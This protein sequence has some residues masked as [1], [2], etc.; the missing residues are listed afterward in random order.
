MKIA[1]GS[2]HAGFHL[3]EEIKK[4]LMEKNIQILDVGTDSETKSC[5]YPDFAEKVAKNITEG[6]ADKG[7]LICATGIGMCITANKFS[8]IRAAQCSEPVTARLSREHNDSN[9]LTLGAKIIGPLLAKD[10]VLVWLNT[11]FTGERHK[12]RVDKIRNIEI[13]LM[14]E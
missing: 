2:D 6:N 7:I 11:E 4:L 1:V 3:K 13:K 8:Q 10:I 12:Y 5:D 14:G 9:I